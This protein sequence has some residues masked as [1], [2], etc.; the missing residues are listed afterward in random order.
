MKVSVIVC[1]YNRCQI[2]DQ[3]LE[4]VAV[5]ELPESVE[6]EVLVVDNN[7]N[8]RT[9]EVIN[10]FREEHP[11]RFRYLF[12]PK[13]GKSNA[14]NAGIREATGDI[15]AFTDD[16][17]IVAPTWLWNLVAALDSGEWSSAGGRIGAA[18]SF[19]CPPWLAL[20][21]DHSLGSVLGFFDLGDKAGASSEPFFGGNVAYRKEVFEKCGLYRTDLGRSGTSLLGCEDTEFSLRVMTS[22]ESLWYEPSAVVYH[23]V[24]RDRLSKSHFLNYFFH[25]GRSRIRESA[26]RADVSGIP[27][28]CFSVPFIVL[29]LLT[30]RAGNWLF[31][32]DAKRRFYFK[33]LVWET[34]GEI[35]ELPRLRLE[36]KQP[37]G[38]TGQVA[39]ASQARLRES[40]QILK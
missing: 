21:G 34:L 14:L 11:D 18:N 6:W 28:W 29:N 39:A 38:N 35:V 3:A 12:E 16:D 10:G 37:K 30:P 23:A 26:N 20:Q 9:R 15:L 36:E 33:C 31:T 13:Q 8:D 2:L 22:G 27:R 32:L 25:H 40:A 5:S 24:P 19:Q 1:T 7:S 17:I 4:S